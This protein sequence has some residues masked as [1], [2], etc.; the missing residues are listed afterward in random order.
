MSLPTTTIMIAIGAMA[1]VTFTLRLLPF[2][3]PDDHPILRYFSG[4]TPTLNALGPSLL[5]GLTAITLI[6][7]L[8]ATMSISAVAVYG[9]GLLAT[10][11]TLIKTRNIGVA[12]IAGVIVY[13]GLRALL[14]S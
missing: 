5:G 14:G 4:Q 2:L 1:V 3:L 10:L 9:L 11:A 12:T 13:A 6:P 8:A 7:D